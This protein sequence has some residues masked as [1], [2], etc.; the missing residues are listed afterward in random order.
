MPD[1]VDVPSTGDR[2]E[3]DTPPSPPSATQPPPLGRRKTVDASFLILLTVAVLAAIGVAWL[4]GPVR[5]V[6][7][8]AAYLSFLVVLSPKILCGFFVAAAVPILVPREVLAR[9]LGRESGWRGLGVA[10]LAGALVPGGPMMIFPLAVGFRAAGAS[11]AT[12]IAFITAWSLYG[13]NRTVI[14]E[15]SFLHID[16]V[17]LRVLICLPLPVL[18]G[19]VASRVLADDARRAGR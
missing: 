3:A 5:V 8:A 15:M 12:I 16:F 14:W 18:A 11:V 7:I 2:P 9:W 19:W 13:I 10:S 4:E 1:T 17:L 6:E